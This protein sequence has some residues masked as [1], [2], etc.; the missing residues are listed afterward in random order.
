[1]LRKEARHHRPG[2]PG[3]LV[4]RWRIRAFEHAAVPRFVLD[5]GTRVQVPG[6]GRTEV[7]ETFAIP[8]LRYVERLVLEQQG[9]YLLG[10]RD[11]PR[12]IATA[13]AGA[14]QEML[15]G[16]ERVLLALAYRG[17]SNCLASSSPAD[18]RM[19]EAGS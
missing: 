18:G 3:A 11:W 9:L 19:Q 7:L 10:L 15:G 13:D 1:M 2:L 17:L 4:K 14:L 5:D 6:D 8:D 12:P 16:D